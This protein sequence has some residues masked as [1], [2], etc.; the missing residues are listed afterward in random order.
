MFNELPQEIKAIIFKI[1]R[2]EAITKRN[3]KN[4]I[5]EFNKNIRSNLINNHIHIIYRNEPEQFTEQE[6]EEQEEEEAE[7]LFFEFEEEIYNNNIQFINETIN[8]LMNNEN[9]KIM[10][11]TK[12]EIY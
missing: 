11:Y 7:E 12:K 3:Y 9:F 1:N 10:K 5:N 6:I 4:V 2:I 8:N